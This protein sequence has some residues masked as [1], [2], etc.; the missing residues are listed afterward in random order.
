M[1]LPVLCV[2][3][4]LVLVINDLEGRLREW[5][6]WLHQRPELG[7]EEEATSAYVANLLGSFGLDPHRGIGRTGVVASLVA[8]SGSRTLGLRAD[9]DALP[10][11]ERTG[12]AYAAQDGR[13][14][15][16]GHDGHMAML[17][18]AAA[19]LADEGGFDGTVRFFFQPAEEHGLGAQAMLDDK[20]L[21]RFPVEQVYGL[22]NMP[23][24]PAG[25]LHTRPAR[26][27][28]EDTFEITITGPRWSRRCSAHGHRP[29]RRR[30][31]SGAGVADDRQ[32]QRRPGGRSGAFVHRDPH[33]RRSQRHPQQVTIKGDTRS[34]DPDVQSLLERRM[35][36]SAP[37]SAQRTGRPAR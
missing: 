30:R 9:M 23:G 12:L 4:T 33:R 29:G 3:G 31:R 17:L 35:R 28:R 32:P 13:M 37:A 16:C 26:S 36:R 27:W 18:G 11:V 24:L 21:E 34:F 7:F 2:I 5:R 8:G 15:A 1:S 10:L 14:H 22:H 19:V 20:L 25:E 6:H